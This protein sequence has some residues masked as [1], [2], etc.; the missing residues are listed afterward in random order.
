M[1]EKHLSRSAILM[2]LLVVVFLGSWEIY[3]RH[4]G[5]MPCSYD[6]GEELWAN[7]RAMVY[8]PSDKA[9]VFIGRLPGSN[10]TWISTPGKKQRG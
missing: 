7:K 4:S 1:P 9:T 3:L 5:V 8:E 2:A 6:D 10:A